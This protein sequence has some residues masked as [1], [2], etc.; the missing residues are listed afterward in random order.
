MEI[1][2]SCVPTVPDSLIDPR[3]KKTSRRQ[4]NVMSLDQFH[5]L[6]KDTPTVV[7][8]TA[9]NNGEKFSD[10]ETWDVPA[11]VVRNSPPGS[12]TTTKEKKP[13]KQNSNQQG[14][15]VVSKKN[16]NRVSIRRPEPKKPSDVVSLD[17]DEV[18]PSRTLILK[19]LPKEVIS[20]RDLRQFFKKV[21]PVNSI[22]ILKDN[23]GNCKGIGFIEFTEQ[24]DA[25]KAL[26]LNKF[27]YGEQKVYVSYAKTRK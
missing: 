26:S 23:D 8:I 1:A 13:P 15:S 27:W 22:K 3:A 18:T 24:K 21:G 9:G 19:N 2:E 16:A 17:E 7:T 5:V 20:E 12:K 4:K 10:A 11:S 14:W 25:T 6:C